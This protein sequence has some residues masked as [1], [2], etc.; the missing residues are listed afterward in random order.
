MQPLNANN[1]RV[2]T[3]QEPDEM[4]HHYERGNGKY[5][6]VVVCCSVVVL[7]C[8]YERSTG[9]FTDVLCEIWRRQTVRKLSVGFA[10]DGVYLFTD[11]FHSPEMHTKPSMIKSKHERMDHSMRPSPL[12]VDDDVRTKT[13]GPGSPLLHVS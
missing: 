7:Q 8:C 5:T 1:F 3:K 9:K 10:E 11:H 13:W 2:V 12:I 4:D 6:V